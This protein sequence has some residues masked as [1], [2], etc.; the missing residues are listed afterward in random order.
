MKFIKTF[1]IFDFSQTLPT[2]SK[3]V[4][5]TFWSCD[6]CNGIWKEF[7]SDCKECKFCSS[8]EI[9]ELSESE[10]YE[11]QKSRLEEDEI[12]DMES[13]R[14]EDS[15]KFVDLHNLKRGKNYVN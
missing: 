8:D 14:K 1:E 11:V 12:E 5:T 6:E 10:W 4:L 13:E 3:N 15:E 9:E 2:T 7:N